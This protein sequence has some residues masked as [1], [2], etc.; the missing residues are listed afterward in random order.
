MISSTSLKTFGSG[1]GSSETSDRESLGSRSHGSSP[2][3]LATLTNPEETPEAQA[4]RLAL[5]RQV[6]EAFADANKNALS[7]IASGAAH[8]AT[9][10]TERLVSTISTLDS[11]ALA[12][13]KKY[14]SATTHFCYTEFAVVVTFC[15]VF[16][17][18][19]QLSGT[20]GGDERRIPRRAPKAPAAR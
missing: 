18:M 2:D 6:N 3:S 7:T 10:M 20:F 8:L 5:V 12:Y 4:Y 16:G 11:A 19:R 14:L 13:L 17:Y 1:S 9:E 15:R